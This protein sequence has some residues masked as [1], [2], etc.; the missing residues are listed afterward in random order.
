M[1][2]YQFQESYDYLQKNNNKNDKPFIKKENSFCSNMSKNLFDPNKC[3]PPNKFKLM[4]FNRL[5]QY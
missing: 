5:K 4:S 2:S 1:E 3:S